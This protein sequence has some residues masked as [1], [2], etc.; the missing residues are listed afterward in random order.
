MHRIA[1]LILS[2]LM[3]TGVVSA[4]TTS[5]LIVDETTTLTFS[6]TQPIY[7][8][9]TTLPDSGLVYINFNAETYFDL[10][11]GIFDNTEQLV[12]E[13][14][15]NSFEIAL[16]D[17]QA[18]DYVIVI[19]ATDTSQVLGD[20][21]TALRSVI[22]EVLPP[23][24]VYDGQ[25][26]GVDDPQFWS[27]DGTNGQLINVLLGGTNL[28]FIL[29]ASDGTPLAIE[30][31][32]DNIF[33]PFL[34]L[35]DDGTYYFAIQTN[36]P[37]GESYQFRAGA[38]VAQPLEPTVTISGTGDIYNPPY[39]SFDSAEGKVWQ[40]N[41]S[42]LDSGDLYLQLLDNDK[43]LA[44][45]EK[46]II[47]DYSSGGNNNPRISPFVAPRSETYYVLLGFNPWDDQ[48]TFAYE[49]QLA[50]DTRLSLVDGTAFT[51]DIGADNGSVTY[52]YDGTAGEVVT[53]T[54]TRTSESGTLALAMLSPEDE[55]VTLGGRNALE[56]R[57]TVELPVDGV[58]RVVL[59]NNDYDETSVLG[60]EIL[61]QINP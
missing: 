3:V 38:I 6:P 15:I 21:V 42:S 2:L 5:S 35:P 51:G 37:E 17:L 56:H 39:F 36:N 23:N 52:E 46:P 58:Y 29:F 53:I 14:Y 1:I 4:Q 24:S 41:A 30:G 19:Q 34:D 60:Y 45:W 47:T 18:G 7:T 25:L 50:P 49:I 20:V 22:S 32:G 16:F 61:L 57:V 9:N 33:L 40:L 28:R 11:V 48:T 43:S 10:Y 54:L 27:I 12:S 13:A 55:V 26:A 31:Y 8:L 59:R 44:W